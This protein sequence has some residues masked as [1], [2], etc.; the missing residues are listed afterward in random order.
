MSATGMTGVLPP[1]GAAQSQ[2]V[3]LF[4]L[5]VFIVFVGCYP[6]SPVLILLLGVSPTAGFVVTAGCTFLLLHAVVTKQ[7]EGRYTKILR[8][9]TAAVAGVLILKI[10][11]NYASLAVRE[12][13]VTGLAWYAIG[14]TLD[15]LRTILRNTAYILAALLFISLCAATISYYLGFVDYAAWNIDYLSYLSQD[16]PLARRGREG[17]YVSFYMPFYL[18]VIPAYNAQEGIAFGLEFQRQNL[19]FAEWSYLSF[20]V[21]PLLFYI[22]GDRQMRARGVVAAIFIVSFLLTFSVW[23]VVTV[24]GTLFLMALNK[25]FKSPLTIISVGAVGLVAAIAVFGVSGVLGILGG[26]KL[27]QFYTYFGDKFDPSILIRPFGVGTE[28]A[29]DSFSDGFRY[30]GVLNIVFVYG[31]AGLAMYV[32]IGMLALFISGTAL[33]RADRIDSTAQFSAIAMMLVL[34][35]GVKLTYLIPLFLF[36]F[37]VLVVKS[38]D[39]KS[40]NGDGGDYIAPR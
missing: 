17:L 32:A 25:L 21:G 36:L 8:W 35:L 27:E 4:L 37:A 9:V 3:L 18:A 14:L 31:I 19:I 22:W 1:Q 5:S 13:M 23:G 28:A 29:I 2:S 11:V 6:S 20:F 34:V 30:Y 7:E 33:R 15:Q 26:N 10:A 24:A 39:G 12:L 40:S 38:L 16:N